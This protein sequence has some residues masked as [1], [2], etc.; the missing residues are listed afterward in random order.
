[1]SAS[2]LTRLLVHTPAHH[3]PMYTLFENWLT[4][5]KSPPTRINVWPTNNASMT[6]RAKA[7]NEDPSW[8]SSS[9]WS[10]QVCQQS[11]SRK[12]L[13]LQKLFPIVGSTDEYYTSL[14]CL[15]KPTSTPSK[16]F[17][18]AMEDIAVN[19]R[20][21]LTEYAAN[22]SIEDISMKEAWKQVDEEHRLSDGSQ[23]YLLHIHVYQAANDDQTST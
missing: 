15:S 9:L 17:N 4:S 19:G 12:Q 5:S 14:A 13:T 23:T 18:A 10:H 11:P 20:P 22:P 3:L 6:T 21:S 8:S 16:P 1:M 7:A 2:R